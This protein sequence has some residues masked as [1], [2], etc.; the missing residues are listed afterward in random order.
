MLWLLQV[1]FQS[2]KNNVALADLPEHV[3]LPMRARWI[4][5]VISLFD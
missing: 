3:H 1:S 2:M 4:R 5:A